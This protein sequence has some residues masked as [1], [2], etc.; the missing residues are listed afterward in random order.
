[1]AQI[2]AVLAIMFVNLEL[3]AS[4]RWPEALVITIASLVV[5]L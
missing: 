2:I 5:S 4:G 3:V 1:M